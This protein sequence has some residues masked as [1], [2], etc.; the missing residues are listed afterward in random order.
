[1]AAC[2]MFLDRSYEDV[3]AVAQDALP[4]WDPSTPSSLSLLWYVCQELDGPVA[5]SRYLID[6]VPAIVVVPST[7]SDAYHHAVFWD[8]EN[9][10]DP[11]PIKP[12]T[13]EY[14]FENFLEVTVR[15]DAMVD[16][17]RSYRHNNSCVRLMNR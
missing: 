17:A 12:V 7:I 1:M 16:F 3:V 14:M 8:G 4:S 5:S 6:G 15:L 10:F 13:R 9:V 2:A 11:S